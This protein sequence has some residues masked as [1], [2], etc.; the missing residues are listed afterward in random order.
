MHAKFTA[1]N[2]AKYVAKTL[3]AGYTAQAAETAI[4]EHTHFDEDDTVV[5]I[6]SAVIGWGAS[7][8]LK[9]LT[10]AAVDKAADS[11]VAFRE[12]RQQKKTAEVA[13]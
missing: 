3:V 12:K 2:V 8:K 4:V 11:I 13:V 5:N 10:D 1:R 7:E 9:P 6:A